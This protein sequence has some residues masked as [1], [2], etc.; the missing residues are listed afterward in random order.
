MA[1]KP[2]PPDELARRVEVYLRHG[3]KIMPA[4]AELGLARDTLS[5][6]MKHAVAEG[7]LDPKVKVKGRVH[8]VKEVR[9]A[10]PKAGK[11]KRYLLTS[12]Q[13]NTK[14]HR[15]FWENLKAYAGR[16]DA[17]LVVGTFTYDLNAYASERSTKKLPSYADTMDAW[18]DEGVMEHAVN[19]RV[20]L[21]PGLMW[22]GEMNILPTDVNPLS[23]LQSYTGR[24]SAIF[25]HAKIEVQSVGSGKFEGTK[26]NYTTGAATQR[27]YIQK[28]AG[29]KAEADHAYCAELVEVDS[30]GN[31][32]V[33][34]LEADAKGTFHD[35]DVKVQ[36]G[37]VTTGNRV[38]ACTW[39]DIHEDRMD[40]KVRAATFGPDGVLDFLRP[41]Y[42]F[43][44]DLLDFGRR[45]HHSIKDPHER[46]RLH[47]DGIESVDEE[48]R[49]SA[50]FLAEEA[51][52]EWCETVVVP[53]NHDE[54]LDRWLREADYR[55]DPVNAVAFLEL[56]LAKYRAIAEGDDAFL[57]LEHALR[58]RGCP[59]QVRFLRR[60]ESFIT[61]HDREGGIENGMHF[62]LGIN[63]A[64]GSAGNIR[65][66][67]RRANGGHSHSACRTGG[68]M[69]VGTSSLLDLGYNRG[70]GSWSH[71]H[72]ITYPN[73][74][75][76]L[77]TLWRGMPFAP[78]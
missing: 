52:R 57:L 40:Q 7:L 17:Q 65:K 29:Q 51:Y 28:K 53:S 72:G 34:Q 36:E 78:R 26:F 50:G 73:A 77:L 13:N 4:A 67:G 38:E 3:K 76:T 55:Y 2:V 35:L 5:K 63:G 23:S 15:P 19:E 56:Q 1:Q 75:R 18:Y 14:L 31:W 74:G 59:E 48:L 49:N 6:S 16:F 25:P 42:Q 30:N 70:P 68:V 64:R 27:N 47:V 20:Q 37:L 43:L 71:T 60:D 33:R 41:R 12:A 54:H 62:D 8:A 66:M 45:S 46:F 44:H 39:G 9:W 10:T 69:Q 11:I 32:W 24:N 58:A 21:A 61:C 22:C